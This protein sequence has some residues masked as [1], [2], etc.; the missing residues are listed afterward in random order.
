MTNAILGSRSGAS[1]RLKAAARNQGA[2][3]PLFL[4]PSQLKPLITDDLLDG[5]LK[6]L[7]YESGDNIEQGYDGAA[8]PIVCDIW[9]KARE[10][11]LLQAQQLN[12]AQ[13]AEILMRGLA[14]VGIIALI[15]EATGYQYER[16]RRDL[17]EQLKKFLSDELRRWVKTFP[18]DYFKHLCRLHG[19]ELRTDM[20]LPQYF[21]KLTNN[22]VYRRIAPGL[23]KKLKER[24]SERGSPSNKLTQ[25]LSEDLGIRAVLVHLGT[26][27]GL[28]KINNNY[29]AFER[30]LNQ[31][32][33][34]Y[35]ETPGLW[36]NPRDWE[37]P[38]D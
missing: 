37:E 21:G 16:P 18:A 2:L 9:L 26:V 17:E 12:K 28:M 35:P 32:A 20:K 31:I 5:P 22:L 24:R 34:I 1:K 30:Q 29:E 19:V 7:E 8:L 15:D 33:P 6:M 27:V 11:E 25:W 23:L 10:Q 13:Q 14:H 36:D 3:L 4:A 38:K